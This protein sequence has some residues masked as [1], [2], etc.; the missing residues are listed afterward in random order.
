MRVKED[1]D[2][3]KKGVPTEAPAG[4]A[5]AATDDIAGSIGRRLKGDKIVG[6][7]SPH[8]PF[9][10]SEP[11]VDVFIDDK[12]VG[13]A[14]V[15]L[16]RNDLA[17][18]YGFVPETGFEFRVPTAWQDGGQH[19]VAVRIAGTEEDLKNSGQKLAF[20]LAK[21]PVAPK[22]DF[23]GSVNEVN[24]TFIAGWAW[25]PGNPNQACTVELR[26]KDE[27]LATA[28]ASRYRA[29]LEQ[30]G[31]G[32]GF[33]AFSIEVPDILADGNTH[34][35]TV[36]SE[37]GQHVLKRGQFELGPVLRWPDDVYASDSDSDHHR[38]VRLPQEE[39]LPSLK[40]SVGVAVELEI[41]VDDV[42]PDTEK[43]VLRLDPAGKSLDRL[44]KLNT[45][46][47]PMG[48]KTANRHSLIYDADSA[49]WKLSFKLVPDPATLE[50][51]ANPMG[52]EA[53]VQLALLIQPISAV[54]GDAGRTI[55][56]RLPM[57]VRTLAPATFNV[58]DAESRSKKSNQLD[59]NVF[60]IGD[61]I[62]RPHRLWESFPDYI[63]PLVF[64]YIDG[65]LQQ[66]LE[67]V[68]RCESVRD[69]W[70]RD[71]ILD[72]KPELLLIQAG[73][74]SGEK[75]YSAKDFP[76]LVS[77]IELC[78][79]T[80]T[81]VV[82]IQD[83]ENA[84][85]RRRLDWA[86]AL[87]D[88]VVDLVDL[89]RRGETSA[90][91]MSLKPFISPGR[92]NPVTLP[93]PAAPLSAL[94]RGE[95]ESV[96]IVDGFWDCIEARGS[97]AY[98]AIEE[99]QRNLH[100]IDSRFVFSRFRA[101]DADTLYWN[102]LGCVPSDRRAEIVA[103][104]DRLA[105]LPNSSSDFL[106]KYRGLLEAMV[107]RC[108]LNVLSPQADSHA[109]RALV[110]DI[111]G[112]LSPAGEKATPLD[113]MHANMA[114]R[115]PGQSHNSV[116]ALNAILERSNPALVRHNRQAMRPK[117]SCILVSKRPVMVRQALEGILRQAYDN[118]EVIVIIH[119]EVRDDALHASWLIDERIR[120]IEYLPKYR[121]LGFCL[122]YAI[123]HASGTYVAKFDD[124]DIYGR[125]HITDFVASLQ[126]KAMDLYVKPLGFVYL[127]ESRTLL[128]M[129]NAL[130]QAYRTYTSANYEGFAGAGGTMILSRD[131]A[132][133]VRF[134]EVRRGGLDSDFAAR[135]VD[136][137]TSLVLGDTNGF[138][139][140]R[141]G[142]AGSHTWLV[143]DQ[144]FLRKG[145]VI[146]EGVSMSTA[147]ELVD[148][149]L[150]VWDEVARGGQTETKTILEGA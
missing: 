19:K 37:G 29:D 6:W 81:Q 101:I 114:A 119:G 13:V 51:P 73:R 44:G 7:V 35:L 135:A 66:D 102:I 85:E 12:P 40:V 36:T 96:Q 131:L 58:L 124:D 20:P 11:S 2:D 109:Y 56:L 8:I 64:G 110:G 132:V 143:D 16:P 125:H 99:I 107:V 3:M 14:A 142:D 17:K 108:G 39:P 10:D 139:L 52:E 60:A 41:R 62:R 148:G 120:L 24:G 105:L 118:I 68:A 49:S 25:A 87:S 134:S 116:D 55:S 42:Y 127:N 53:E 82:F 18:L 97:D 150:A 111:F 113:F 69:D 23:Q 144:S 43:L 128:S 149:N 78:R 63:P 33:H 133:R 67:C 46:V 115:L 15:C 117:I 122:N 27:I 103:R 123:D 32:Q 147:A 4:E 21:V 106:S 45:H 146:A 31:I 141:Y 57:Q 93:K 137:G 112:D 91:F 88:I 94:A 104:Y 9:P 86:V 98:G 100:I 65:D 74:L 95:R 48:L 90:K 38:V 1:G 140:C 26:Q 54:P 89:A 50:G 28:I 77:T 59:M 138:A 92:I 47:Y 83:V 22:N 72:R 70:N 84:E 136:A 76:R 75:Q 126:W 34:T 61:E 130:D 79:L 121:T 129:P 5:P 145:I 80:R 71:D 30:N